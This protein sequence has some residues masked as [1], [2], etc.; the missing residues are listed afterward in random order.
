M[1]KVGNT[2]IAYAWTITKDGEAYVEGRHTVVY[3]DDEGRPEREGSIRIP[4]D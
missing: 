1:E 3:V 2:S 4:V